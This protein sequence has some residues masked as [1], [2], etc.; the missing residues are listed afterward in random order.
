MDEVGSEGRTDRKPKKAFV[1]TI[2]AQKKVHH[3]LKRGGR[4]VSHLLFVAKDAPEV[5]YPMHPC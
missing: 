2:R 4:R 1:F 5:V 3:A